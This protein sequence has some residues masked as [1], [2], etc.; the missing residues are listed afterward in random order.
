MAAQGLVV[1]WLVWGGGSRSQRIRTLATG[2]LYAILTLAAVGLVLAHRWPGIVTAGALCLSGLPLRWRLCPSTG[3][4]G[5]RGAPVSAPVGQSGPDWVRDLS[6]AELCCAW[7]ITT[8]ALPRLRNTTQQ[9]I[10]V[11][12]RAEYLDELERRDPRGF[13]RWLSEGRADADPRPF[14]AAAA[15]P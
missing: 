2:M 9:E 10:F 15:G 13:D 6:T 4:L 7:E 1:G 12:L 5:D 8:A 14:F 11:K 3:A